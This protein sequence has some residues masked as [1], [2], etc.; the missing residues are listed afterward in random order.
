VSRAATQ[1]YLLTVGGWR[2]TASVSS[3]DGKISKLPGDD[4]HGD[5]Q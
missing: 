3:T 1:T 4:L 2:Q 5:L